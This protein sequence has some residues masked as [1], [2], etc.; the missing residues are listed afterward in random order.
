[1]AKRARQQAIELLEC[2]LFAHQ[3]IQSLF[4]RHAIDDAF[5]KEIVFGVSRHYYRLD[6]ILKHLTKKPI[7]NKTMGEIQKKRK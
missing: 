3:S 5:V 1:M 7:K 2:V 4:A 6:C